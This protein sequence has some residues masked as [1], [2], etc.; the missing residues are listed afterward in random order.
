M[1]NAIFVMHAGNVSY[2]DSRYSSIFKE[3]RQLL[4]ENVRDHH[5]HHPWKFL[6]V[7]RLKYV[8]NVLVNLVYREIMVLIFCVHT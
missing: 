6:L 5:Y 2:N 4:F 8:T 1:I 3:G 7:R